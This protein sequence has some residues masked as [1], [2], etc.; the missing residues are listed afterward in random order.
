MAKYRSDW[1]G[2]GGGF[3]WQSFVSLV[4]AGPLS[5]YSILSKF[6]GPGD[7]SFLYLYGSL[8]GLLSGSLLSLSRSSWTAAGDRSMSILAAMLFLGS[9]WDAGRQNLYLAL[10]LS[11]S[12]RFRADRDSPRV[13]VLPL[14]PAVRG[15]GGT[16]LRTAAGKRSGP[17]GH[18]C[19]DRRRPFPGR[20]RPAD[21]LQFGSRRA[22]PDA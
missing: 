17:M 19:G 10:S 20:F 1:L 22:R 12:A 18:C 4:A 5:T 13:H 11:A 15:S 9:L 16:G 6:R 8:A 14:H 7:I 2:T 3:Y 21:E